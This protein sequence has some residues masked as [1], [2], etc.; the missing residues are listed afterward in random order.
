MKRKTILYNREVSYLVKKSARARRLRLAIYCDASVVVTIPTGFNESKIEHF[1]KIKAGWILEKIDNFL[2]AGKKIQLKGGKREYKKYRE[3]AR[4][5]VQKRIEEINK[6]YKFPFKKIFIKNHKTRWGSCSK[7][8]NLNFNYKIIFLPEK[9]ADYI[10]AHE[11]C[12]L[13]EFN[14]SQ[15]FW[16]LVDKVIPN[17]EEVVGEL[18]KNVF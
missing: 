1:L 9:L 4:E 18:K 6:I 7:K 14:H 11:L 10:I 5:F 3:Q 8:G 13:K 16:N 15:K 2:R 12:H 17:Y